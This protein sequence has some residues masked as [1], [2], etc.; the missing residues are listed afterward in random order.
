MS[1]EAVKLNQKEGDLVAFQNSKGLA[2]SSMR[3]GDGINLS[4]SSNGFRRTLK[5]HS[6]L[7][8][9]TDWH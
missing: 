5:I 7:K 9:P 4:H 8:H 1:Q 3:S 6:D 2:H